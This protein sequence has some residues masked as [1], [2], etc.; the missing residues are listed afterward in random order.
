MAAPEATTARDG[1]AASST[2]GAD[3]ALGM[4]RPAARVGDYRDVGRKR[5]RVEI[6]DPGHPSW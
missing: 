1:L 2:T 6:L 3:H 4:T 5:P